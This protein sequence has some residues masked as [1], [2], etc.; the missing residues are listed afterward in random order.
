MEQG[1]ICNE[2][3]AQ[4]GSDGIYAIQPIPG[5]GQGVIATSKIPKGT[6][7]LSEAPIFKMPRIG[8]DRKVVNDL[9]IKAVKGLSK[10]DQRAFFSL[11]N[12][13]GRDHS[14]FLGIARTNALPLGSEAHEGG[15]FLEASR[16][17]HS[18]QHNAQN[19]WNANLGR[20]TIHALRDIEEGQEITISYLGSTMEYAERQRLLKEKFHF[21]CG[22][23]LCSA[24]LAQRKESDIRLRKMQLI[25]DALGSLGDAMSEYKAA[26]HLAHTMFRLFKA[27]GV[28]DAR[29]P[30]AYYDAFQIAI[31]NGDETR[32]KVFA[33]RAHAVR[34]IIEGDD[35]PEV[36]RSAQFINRPSKHM[37]FG[38]FANYPEK[39][40]LPQKVDESAFEDWLWKEDELS[41]EDECW[42]E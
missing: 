1:R 20:I 29:I 17:N 2:V 21:D 23:E 22:C 12:A 42:S 10:T 13:H 40:N 16:I 5:K 24:T 7:I 18:C 37:L 15:I 41:S 28:W 25:D 35:S 34:V 33:E 31:A 30:R 36:A 4:A 3:V 38:I 9:I 39:V 26:L 32:A 6:R 19:T 14:P 8:S 11:H 27:E